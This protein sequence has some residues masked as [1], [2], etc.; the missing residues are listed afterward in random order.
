MPF[1]V[2]PVFNSHTTVPVSIAI[3]DTFHLVS[4][5][6]RI[7][8]LSHR[9]LRNTMNENRLH[10]EQRVSPTSLFLIA[11]YPHLKVTEERK[12]IEEVENKLNLA[13]TLGVCSIPYIITVEGKTYGISYLKRSIEGDKLVYE[14]STKE[15]FESLIGKT[16]E[17]TLPRLAYRRYLL[18]LEKESYEDQLLDLWIALESIFVPDGKKGEI[19]YKVR[20]RMA[21]YF[22]QSFDERKKISDFI[23]T[24]YN[25]RSEIVHS[26]KTLGS[27]LK[28]EVKTLRRMARAALLNIFALP[29]PIQE[30]K[31]RLDECVLAGES[32]VSRYPQT[33]FETV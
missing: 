12:A 2:A 9:Y 29:V 10:F 4:G 23:K 8:N 3:D 18:S 6:E 24:S 26:G 19:T 22:A 11:D 16:A 32:Y 17:N 30:L 1:L 20:Y 7:Y 25:H 27:E 21:Y 28:D 5:N 33:F 31:K 13:S 15:T 14:G